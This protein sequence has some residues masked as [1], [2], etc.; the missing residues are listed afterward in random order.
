MLVKKYPL[1]TPITEKLFKFKFK[2]FKFIT[3]FWS[4]LVSNPPATVN[5]SGKMKA[6][7]MYIIYIIYIYNIYV[8]KYIHIYIL[9]IYIYIY[10]IYIY[11]HIHIHVSTYLCYVYIHNIQTY[12]KVIQVKIQCLFL[13]IFWH[14]VFYNFMKSKSL[15]TEVHILE[16]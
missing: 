2:L 4:D 5:W 10:I 8:N 1:H 14:D 16:S 7:F 12:I 11:I 6:S 13:K 3:I 9:Y 15:F